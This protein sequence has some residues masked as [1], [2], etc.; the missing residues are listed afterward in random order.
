MS[1]PTRLSPSQRLR[2]IQ[3]GRDLGHRLHLFLTRPYQVVAFFPLIAAGAI[4][5]T[6]PFTHWTHHSLL[7]LLILAGASFTASCARF[8]VGDRPPRWT[9]HVDIFVGVVLISLLSSIQAN[10]TADFQSFYVWIVVFAALYFRPLAFVFYLGVVGA[11]Y[12]IVLSIGPSAQN[13]VSAWM[14]TIGSSAILGVVVLSLVSTLER[15]SREDVLTGLANRRA[16]DARLDEELERARRNKTAVSIALIDVDN[17]KA[18]NDRDG[19]PAGDRLLC[20]L[21]DG[22]RN[23]IRG[24]GDFLGRLGGDEFG[25]VVPS[26]NETGIQRLAQRLHET[27][28]GGVSCS[29]GAATWDGTETAAVLF[30]R[31]D[32]A[33]YEAKRELHRN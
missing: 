13:P 27:T 18:V 19:H 12:A 4:L 22:W 6:L 5:T 31:A 23:T 33:M 28:P 7:T 29:I 20:Q 14:A 16:W 3:A 8:A 32:E 24:S 15:T 10:A 21:A 26:S 9:L 11:A 1:P 17:F 2:A 25:V 30:R